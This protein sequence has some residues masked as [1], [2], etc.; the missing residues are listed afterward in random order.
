MSAA[1]VVNGRPR[2]EVLAEAL[3]IERAGG[4]WDLEHVSAF[5]GLGT[6]VLHRSDCPRDRERS[7]TGTRA[8]LVFIPSKVRAW[9]A[10][11]LL[12]STIEGAA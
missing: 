3:E 12:P 11:L 2:A 10:S 8:R 5:T 4:T 9:K 6:S 7:L 1:T